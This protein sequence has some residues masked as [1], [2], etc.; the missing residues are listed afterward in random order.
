MTRKLRL[1]FEH[2]IVHD[3]KASP[4]KFWSYVKSRTK[5]KSKIP[6]LK[7]AKTESEKADVLNDFFASTFTNENMEGIPIIE[8]YPFLGEYLDTFVIS[9]EMVQTKLEQLNEGKTPGPY[10]WHPLM[11]KN[12]ADVVASPLSQLFQKSL[13]EGIVPSTWL[14]ACI[15]AIHKKGSKNEPGN[16]RP[17]SIISIICKLMESIVRD[18]LVSHMER[19]NL[20]SKKQ[21][22]FV[23]L[24][25][26]MTN[27][28]TCIELWTEMIEHG[29]PIDIIY[30]DFAKA[31]D[32]VPH[33]RLVKKLQNLGIV[34]N[35]LK[36]IEAFLSGR[37]QCVRV[38]NE[39]SP[40]A[41]VKSGIPQGSV[42]VPILFVCFINDLPNMVNSRCQLFADDA[43]IFR[44]VKTIND[45][46][47][48][49]TR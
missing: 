32:R 23:P 27:L 37:S 20:F 49:I 12:L 19:N 5:T 36:W 10:K 8:P 42:L 17:I 33:R 28:L 38:E 34:G 7:K 6:N 26:C 13:N 45:I 40:W 22:G 4:K 41:P 16:Y 48:L 11:L 25:N 44:S 39:L 14:K 3:I 24:R 35:T 1:K 21:H 31:F 2:N 43:K 9:Q 46:Y 47:Q 29:L 30:T 18:K 15:T